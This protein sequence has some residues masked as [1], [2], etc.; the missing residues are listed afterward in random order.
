M[1]TDAATDT[2]QSSKANDKRASMASAPLVYNPDQS[3][4]WDQMWDTFCVLASVGGPPHRG[5]ML[6]AQVDADPNSEGY[7]WAANEIIRGI[8]LVSGLPAQ[9]AQTGWIAIECGE[10]SKAHWLSDQIV[11][12]N[13]E[14]YYAVTQLFV[15]VG[16]DFTLKGEI[17]NVITVVAKATHYWTEHLDVAVKTSLVWEEKLK[18]LTGRIRRWLRR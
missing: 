4:A 11:Q 5:D 15:P 16:D 12:E 18:T 6:R 8:A 10:A 7:Q 2:N 9:T 13:V 14:S 1:T 17:K 3:V